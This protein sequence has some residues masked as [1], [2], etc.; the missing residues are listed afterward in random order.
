MALRAGL[1]RGLALLRGTLKEFATPR[2]ELAKVGTCL[3][4]R[5]LCDLRRGFAILTWVSFFFRLC[6]PG[7]GTRRAA[8]T[9]R[10]EVGN[11]FKCRILSIGRN[12][13]ASSG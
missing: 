10:L 7:D 11:A 2:S 9:Q 5:R 1:R 8:Y 4:G 6:L 3:Q 12:H 13:D